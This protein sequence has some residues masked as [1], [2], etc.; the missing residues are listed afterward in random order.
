MKNTVFIIT[1]LLVAVIAGYLTYT[2]WFVN[3]TEVVVEDDIIIDEEVNEEVEE[4]V[5]PTAT[6]SDGELVTLEGRSF[7][8]TNFNDEEVEG[9]YTLDFTD[10]RIQAK[11]CNGMGG[12]YTADNGVLAGMLV[13]TKMFC[14]EPVNLMDIENGFGKALDEG[15]QFS[16]S[17]TGITITSSEDEFIFENN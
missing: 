1:I 13:S 17:E 7:S 11:F 6:N 16:L 14:A 9:A 5:I 4:V 3:K 12:V 2:T 15:A 8:L 10:G